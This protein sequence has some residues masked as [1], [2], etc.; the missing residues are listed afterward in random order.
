MRFTLLKTS[1]YQPPKP[2]LQH[3]WQWKVF[4]NCHPHTHTHAHTP[5]PQDITSQPQPSKVKCDRLEYTLERKMIH[6]N[7]RTFY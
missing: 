1:Q 3:F 7:A 5:P 6:R 4:V 2:Q